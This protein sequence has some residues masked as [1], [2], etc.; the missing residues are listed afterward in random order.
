MEG[1]MTLPDYRQYKLISVDIF[2]TLLL[3]TVAKAVDVF[4]AVWSEARRREMAGSAISDKEFMKL[5]MEMERRARA[6]ASNREVTLYDIYKQFPAFISENMQD[7]MD[8]E[9]ECE[10]RCCYANPVVVPWL[11][12]AR[13]YGCLLVLVSDMYFGSDRIQEILESSGIDI[14]MFDEIIV[15]NEHGCNKQDGALFDVL[16]RKYPQYA[17]GQML[18]IGDNKNAD[19]NQPLRKGMHAFH[20]DVVPEKLYSIYDYEKIRHDVLHPEI[21]S[22]R[23]LAVSLGEYKDQERTAYELGSAVIGPV[24]SLYVSWVC[25]RLEESG[26]QRIYPF[27]REGYVLGKLLQE[28]S[29]TNGLGLSVHPIYISRKVT[30]IPSIKEVTREEVE[31]MIGARNLTIRESILLMGLELSGFSAFQEYF[32]VR[33]KETHKIRCRDSSLKEK[34]IDTFL[35]EENK[36]K[37]E[38]YIRQERK[39]LVG[40]L[41]Q[42]IGDFENIATID[43]GFF[44]RIQM[45]MEQ[46]LDIEKISHCIKHFLAVGVTGDKIFDGMDFEGAFGTFAENTDLIPTI[47][48]TTDVMEKLVSVTEGST[49]GYEEKDGRW[50]PVQDAGVDNARLTE[51]VFQGIFDFQKLW[52]AFC[53]KKPEAAQRCVEKRRETLMIL[54]RLIDMPRKCEA[55]ML[56]GLEADTNFGTDYKKGIITKEHLELGKKMGV[57]VLDKCNVSYTYK[58]SN[59][60]WPKGAVTLLDEYY[61]VRRALKNGTQNEIIKSMQEV[62]E[63]VERDGIRE[64]AL[65]G[66]GENGRQF[67]FLCRMYHIEVKCFIDRK[68]SIWGTRKEGIEVMGLDEAIQRGCSEYIVTSLFSISEITDFILERY[69]KLGREPVIYSV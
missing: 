52:L 33:Y 62:V 23:K 13:Q 41:A 60:T 30:Y 48:R 27:M 38:C 49:V 32:D 68:E 45:W 59:V 35:E 29:D 9:L 4:E 6:M 10:K 58:N 42:E 64:V 20:Y 22:L 26:I 34:I 46:C 17:V 19:Y 18:H 61:Y 43:I 36:K 66:A 63:Q 15:S 69:K 8:L 55:E 16:F 5:R 40:Y 53:K 56:A 67:Y 50:G 7:L 54:H 2:D 39:K 3:R 12:E 51:I 65:Y 31:N 21:L 14:S 11:K 1:K 25:K 47:H 57:D 24:L 44:G 37:I 28:E